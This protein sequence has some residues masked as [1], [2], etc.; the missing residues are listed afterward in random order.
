M[1]ASHALSHLSYSPNVPAEDA[2][3]TEGMADCQEPR[4]AAGRLPARAYPRLT[5]AAGVATTSRPAVCRWQAWAHGVTVPSTPDRG[6][7]RNSFWRHMY[8]NV[9]HS[10]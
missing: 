1:T 4:Q 2:K 6:Y 5:S 9:L 10:P 3:S 8:T 7:S